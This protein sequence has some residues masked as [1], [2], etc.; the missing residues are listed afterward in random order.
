MAKLN[1]E[2]AQQL[3]NQDIVVIDIRRIEQIRQ[4]FMKGSISLSSIHQFT[5]FGPSLSTKEAAVLLC[6]E[7]DNDIAPWVAQAQ[8]I[9]L[10]IA[11]WF[12]DEMHIWAAAGGA[13]DLVIDV[14][15]DELMMDIPFDEKLIVMDLRTPVAF[16]Q[17]H[18]KNAVNLPLTSIADP[19]RLS[20]IEDDDN[21]Y[22]ISNSDEESFF[23]ATLLKKH[24]LHN[25]RVVL[26]G[27]DAVKK[28]KNAADIVKLPKQLN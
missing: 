21:L 3:I 15:P 16:G 17:E 4:G 8:S 11:G 1:V 28:Q 25:L 23:A 26:G 18:L 19:M 20:A 2:Q 9:G 7:L 27:W 24:G 12:Q 6:A 14:E 22:I 5:Q 13:I 10:S